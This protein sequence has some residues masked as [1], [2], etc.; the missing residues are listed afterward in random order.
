MAQLTIAFETQ[1]LLS[2]ADSAKSTDWPGGLAYKVISS[3]KEKYQPNDRIAVVEL[4][5]KLNQVDLKEYEDPKILFERIATIENEYRNTSSSLSNADMIAIILEKALGKYASTLAMTQ[6]ANP[7]NL[8]LDDLQ[9]AMTL[10]Y[11]LRTQGAKI[12]GNGKELAPSAFSGKCYKCGLVGHKANTCTTRKKHHE[13]K[14][15]KFK[16]KCNLCGKIG[17]KATDCWENED[18]AGK[19]PKWYKT[20]TEK[21][22]I[23]KNL[24][25]NGTTQS[26]TEF[27]LMASNVKSFSSDDAILKDTNIF[28]ADT[29]ATSDTTPH[30]IG[31]SN[32]NDASK[33]DRITDA[34]GNNI[35]GNKVGKL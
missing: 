10:E 14:R 32:M 20:N 19:R 25:D 28:I 21:N 22:L 3:L 16:G 29:G 1:A 6:A 26:T 11:R 4:K 17:H 35:K 9:R 24:S 13:Y 2:L 15:K 31:I 27:M 7:T 18:N 33:M 5:R 8:T 30:L 23:S 34:A 12:D